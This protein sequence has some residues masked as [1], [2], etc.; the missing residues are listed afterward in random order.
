MLE[1]RGW[2]RHRSLAVTSLTAV[3][4]YGATH[5]AR[6]PSPLNRSSGTDLE[7]SLT[8]ES[9][10][11]MGIDKL[12]DNIAESFPVCSGPTFDQEVGDGALINAFNSL[13][14]DATAGRGAAA[15]VLG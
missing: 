11:G 13:R 5:L 8:F 15:P 3:A 1:F 2:R 9:E 12:E 10:L 14:D 7:I 4:R 6:Y